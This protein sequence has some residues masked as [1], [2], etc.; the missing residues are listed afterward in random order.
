[1]V[2]SM[3]PRELSRTEADSPLSAKARNRKPIIVAAAGANRTVRMLVS[4][5]KYVTFKFRRG[6]CRGAER[7][8]AFQVLG[9]CPTGIRAGIALHYSTVKAAVACRCCLATSP[10]VRWRAGKTEN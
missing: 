4:S 7:E 9:G 8:V 1:M 5:N 10:N 6:S 3:G 2:G